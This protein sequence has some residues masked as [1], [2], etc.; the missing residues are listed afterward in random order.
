[1]A[2]RN[3]N[4]KRRN[5]NRR[6][7]R[8]HRSVKRILAERQQTVHRLINEGNVTIEGSVTNETTTMSSEATEN[9]M[10]T[11]ELK[12][13]VANWVNQNRIAKTAVNSL[14]S[15]LIA[16]GLDLPKDYRTLLKTPTNVEI[17]N[18][19]GGEFWYNGIK[20]NLKTIFATLDSDI[21]IMLTINIDGLPLY[22]GSK[23]TFYPILAS[24]HSEH[25]VLFLRK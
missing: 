20:N 21:N 13:D 7:V 9:L 11:H 5:S 8:F 23:I 15:I 10:N 1:M 18:T 4:S 3:S 25:K 24:I 6:H 12:N 16:H 17:A 14:L 2:R 19:A 22:N